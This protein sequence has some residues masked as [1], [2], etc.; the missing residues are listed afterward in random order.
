MANN[1]S[2]SATELTEGTTVFIRGKLAFA[3]LTR[4]IDGDELA[5]ADQRRVQN[6]MSPVGRPHTTATITEAEVLFAD[7]ANPTTE[8]QFVSERRYT[9]KKNP[10]SGAN[11]SIDSKGNNL[12]IIAIPSPKGD[13][14]F[15]QDTSG[16]ELA[17]G[18][19]V[20]LVLRVYKP[21]SF[22]NRGLAL[23]QV[24][25]NEPVRYYG[26]SGAT[27][28]ELAARGIVFNTPPKPV[29]ASQASP[30]GEAPGIEEAEQEDYNLPGPETVAAA[31]AAAPQAQAPAQPAQPVQQAAP[32]AQPAQPAQAAQPAQE[33]T[34]EQKLARLE[35]ENAALKD[36]G[37]AVGASPWD[38]Q[39]GG[40]QPTQPGITY[41]G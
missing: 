31:P 13:G 3:R 2:V 36:S 16:R 30:V 5:A 23:D 25:V 24:V 1:Y 32:A 29:A 4:L 39:S 38:S 15:D 34:L 41:G 6:G 9:S 12:P 18:L 17:Q 28:D 11:Y 7:P 40:Q 10:D 27:S 19:D 33:E 20:T 35:A 37:S 14:T 22:N 8:E 26:A 21:K